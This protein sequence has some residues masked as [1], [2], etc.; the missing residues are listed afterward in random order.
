[1]PIIDVFVMLDV[2]YIVRACYFNPFPKG[3]LFLHSKRNIQIEL[4]WQA[5]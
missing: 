4:K 5:C 3:T 1:M 2:L